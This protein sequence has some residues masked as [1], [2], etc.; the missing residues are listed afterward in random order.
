MPQRKIKESFIFAAVVHK[1]FVRICLLGYCTAHSSVHKINFFAQVLWASLQAY[2][3]VHPS[4]MFL[5]TCNQDRTVCPEPSFF[6]LISFFSPI[7]PRV[8]LHPNPVTFVGCYLGE[9]YP[10]IFS[11]CYLGDILFLYWC[12]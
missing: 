7:V 5:Y 11:M 2:W 6:M 4:I 1:L 8:S 12:Y 9:H 10:Q 3:S